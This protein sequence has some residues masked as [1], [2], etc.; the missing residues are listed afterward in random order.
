MNSAVHAVREPHHRDRPAG[1][2]AQH[3][4]RDPGVVVD[5][6]RFGEPDVGVEDLLEVRE[7]ELAATDLDDRFGSDGHA[8][9]T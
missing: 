1:E 9:R 7:G 8:L 2:M 5:D 3:H 6:G 4:R